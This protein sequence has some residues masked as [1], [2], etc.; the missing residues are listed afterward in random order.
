MLLAEAGRLARAELGVRSFVYLL[1]PLSPCLLTPSLSHSP[2]PLLPYSSTPL[3]P[4]PPAPLPAISLGD[5]GDDRG[6]FEFVVRN[7]IER[8]RRDFH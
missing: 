3:L 4:C 5:R 2:A 1:V 6:F 8:S 7:A